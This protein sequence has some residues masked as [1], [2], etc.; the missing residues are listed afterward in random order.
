[1]HY[2][3]TLGKLNLFLALKV[4]K[5][6]MY[7]HIILELIEINKKIFIMEIEKGNE[8]FMPQDLSL[9]WLPSSFRFYD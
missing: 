6:S 1:M 7:L 8:A 4:F 9:E 2:Q 5:G 3:T